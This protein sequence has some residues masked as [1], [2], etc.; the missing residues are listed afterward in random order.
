MAT[1]PAVIDNDPTDLGFPPAL[2]LELAA[3]TGSVRDICES[4][5]VDRARYAELRQNP[6]FIQACQEALAIVSTEGGS[7]KAKARTMAEAFLTRMWNLATYPDLD[8]VPAN[9]QADLMKFVVRVAG[10]DAS[11]EQKASAAGKA[12]ATNALQINIHLS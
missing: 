9:V 7:F 2:P 5:G 8:T 3:K 12:T 1:L 6:V 10:L 4:Y 11:I